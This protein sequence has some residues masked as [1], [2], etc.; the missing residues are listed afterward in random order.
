MM[1]VKL[2]CYMDDD[3]GLHM[4][5]GVQRVYGSTRA[6]DRHQYIH[7]EIILDENTCTDN[8]HCMCK[9]CENLARALFRPTHEV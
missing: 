3:C 7:A 9:R 2:Q 8:T 6:N 5:A 4:H 1:S